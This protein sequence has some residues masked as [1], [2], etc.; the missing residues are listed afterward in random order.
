MKKLFQILAMA[1]MAV[2]LCNCGDKDEPTPGPTPPPHNPIGEDVAVNVANVSKTWELTAFSG[3]AEFPAEGQAAYLELTKEGKFELYQ[4]NINCIG[5]VL[6]TGNYELDEAA[7]SITGTYS[8]GVKWASTYSI[9]T[10]KDNSMG[11][12]AGKETTSF[13]LATEIPAEIKEVATPAEESRAASE[14]RLL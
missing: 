9:T 11:W 8:D 12:T 7:K 13:T 2:T 4:K 6:Y 5:V 3:S 10:M 1:M 14:I